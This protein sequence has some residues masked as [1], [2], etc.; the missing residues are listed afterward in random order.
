M[1]RT[2]EELVSHIRSQTRTTP[3]GHWRFEGGRH[4]SGHGVIWYEGRQITVS[5]LSAHLYLGL[6]LKRLD[7]FACHKP[8]CPYKDC[9]NPNCLYIGNAKENAKDRT[10]I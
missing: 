5:R 4:H 10:R 3:D 8:S 1:A 9:W 6:E 2:I 7:R